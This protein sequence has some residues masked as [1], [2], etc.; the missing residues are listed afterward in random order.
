MRAEAYENII[1]TAIDCLDK[2]GYAATTAVLVSKESR[3]TR[4]GLL[5]YFPARDDLLVAVAEHVGSWQYARYKEELIK[6]P[7]GLPRLLS[8]VHVGWRIALEP[9]SIALTEI[10][11][12]VRS[13]PVLEEKIFPILERGFERHRKASARMAADAGVVDLETIEH[14]VELFFASLQGLAIRVKASRGRFNAAAEVDMIVENYKSTIHR[15]LDE[16]SKGGLS[17][18]KEPAGHI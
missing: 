1:K 14:M 16:Q 15:V 10:M 3:V 8:G 9:E 6:L 4:S 13:N 18:A 17:V 11:V 7:R 2:Y 12:G 5:H